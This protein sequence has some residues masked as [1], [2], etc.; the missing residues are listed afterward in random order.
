MKQNAKGFTL[1]E[2]LF[3]AAIFA[4]SLCGILLTYANMFVLTD[5]SRGFTLATNAVQAQM[6]QVKRTGYDNILAF[7]GTQFDLNGFAASDS[8]AIIEAADQTYSDLRRVRIVASFRVRGRVIGEDA[9]LNGILDV[10]AGEDTNGNLRLDSPVELV[11][12]ISR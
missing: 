5:M 7:N 8:E 11:T 12:L 4:A 2:I 6:E 9:N 10:G 1:I 3:A